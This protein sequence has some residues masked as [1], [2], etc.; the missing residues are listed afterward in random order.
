MF[1]VS[2]HVWG[3]VGFVIRRCALTVS[4]EIVM[5]AVVGGKVFVGACGVF[6]ADMI[7]GFVLR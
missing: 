2:G 7:C 3:G 1:L 6:G 5:G 4:G